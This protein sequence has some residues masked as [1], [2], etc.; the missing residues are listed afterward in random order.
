[1]LSSFF[2]L[3]KELCTNRPPFKHFQ[4]GLSEQIPL[5]EF[6]F[7]FP[8]T[9]MLPKA[10]LPKAATFMLNTV[11]DNWTQSMWYLYYI[12]IY[13]NAKRNLRKRRQKRLLWM[14]ILDHQIKISQP[15]RSSPSEPWH[16]AWFVLLAAVWARGSRSILLTRGSAKQ[17]RTC[18]GSHLSAIV[19]GVSWHSLT[20]NLTDGTNNLG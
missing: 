9:C 19:S 4:V 1:M 8:L 20:E 6:E 15:F 10:N 2:P 13:L 17:E 11:S 5:F 3:L 18:V 7:F 16:N 12:L 14:A